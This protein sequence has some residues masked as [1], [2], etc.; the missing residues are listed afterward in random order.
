L[1]TS[2]SGKKK[3]GLE[4]KIQFS[5]LKLLNIVASLEKLITSLKLPERST[6]WSEYYDEAEQR[7]DYVQQ[8][9]K[10][11]RQWLNE[12]NEIKT[13]ADLGAN[14][15]EFSRIAADKGID[16]IA[17]DFD[18][19]VITRL[20]KKIKRGKLKNILP[21]ILDLSN[22]SPAIGVNN[23]ER[24]SFI[25][26][27]HVDMVMALALVHHLAVGKNIPFRMIAD[28]FS[29]IT[30]YLIIEFIPKE[31]LKVQMMLSNKKDIYPHYNEKEFIR[32]FENN[33]S[34]ETRQ[35]ILGSGRILFLM[36]K[37]ET[38]HNNI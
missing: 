23:K 26:R 34:V 21:L 25:Q 27:A 22:P 5:K 38:G 7:D 3:Q 10:I 16:T 20:Y 37:R 29:G 11:I 24:T 36:K 9:Q 30:A 2:V 33:F 1:H 28:L 15:G 8:K 17:V 13:I 32:S 18:H 31:D 12:N 6:S 14:Q 35:E 4:K 19:L